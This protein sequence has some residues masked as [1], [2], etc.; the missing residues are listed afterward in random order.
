MA[1]FGALQQ[2]LAGLA[3]VDGVTLVDIMNL[4]APL[5][6][7][8]RKMLKVSLSLDSLAA[9]IQLPVSETRQL[10]DSLV[11]KGFVKTE[12]QSGQG[13][14]VYKVYFARMRKHNLPAALV[15]GE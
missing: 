12:E 9:E 14:Q 1:T 7:A 15:D 6:A 11:E 3:R 4:P 13:G 8:L 2:E 5:D 10:M